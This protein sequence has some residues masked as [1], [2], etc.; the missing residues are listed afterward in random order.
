[1]DAALARMHAA[2][3]CMTA[4]VMHRAAFVGLLTADNV[5]EFMLIVS[6]L[7]EHR[8]RVVKS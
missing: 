1:L 5:N 2:E 3:G 6:A 7:G 8:A 4:P